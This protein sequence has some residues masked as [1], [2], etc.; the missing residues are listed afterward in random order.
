MFIKPNGRRYTSTV[1]LLSYSIYLK[2]SYAYEA[3]RDFFPLPH[4]D[5]L[6]HLTSN[7]GKTAESSELNWEYLKHYVNKL[8]DYERVVALY[9][10]EI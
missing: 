5:H 1:F 2:S 6:K 10:D 9:A 7:I 8:K 3:L 4:A